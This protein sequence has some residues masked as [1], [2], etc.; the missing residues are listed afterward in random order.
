MF[1][2]IGVDLVTVSAQDLALGKF[3]Y[4][5]GHRNTNQLPTNGVGFSCRVYV[6]QF[7]RNRVFIVTTLSAPSFQFVG[8]YKV[9][10][11]LETISVVLFCTRS[12][13][14]TCAVSLSCTTFRT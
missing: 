3:L 2:F 10:L 4:Q 5:I 7:E 14:R 9:T 13:V 6:V 11:F 12:A 1:V 8:I